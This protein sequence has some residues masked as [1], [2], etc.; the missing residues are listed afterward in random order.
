MPEA[1]PRD[2]D[3]SVRGVGPVGGVGDDDV[4]GSS[5]SLVHV[6]WQDDGDEDAGDPG[7]DGGGWGDGAQLQILC[8]LNWS[9]P[10]LRKEPV[11]W[12]Y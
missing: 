5:G 11:R 10:L 3:D 9:P 7:E 1:F 4:G 6:G 2:G 8:P 12:N